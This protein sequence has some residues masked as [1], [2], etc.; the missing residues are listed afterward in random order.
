M[1]QNLSEDSVVH[2]F[3]P[4]IA[5]RITTQTAIAQ[6]HTLT[7]PCDIETRLLHNALTRGFQPRPAAPREAGHDSI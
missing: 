7:A 1:K 4:R 2:L 3:D 5:G 6:Y